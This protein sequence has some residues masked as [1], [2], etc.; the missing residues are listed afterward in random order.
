MLPFIKFLD[1]FKDLAKP[2]NFTNM[3]SYTE[4]LLTPYSIDAHRGVL[5]EPPGNKK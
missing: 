4:I 1:F 2:Q 5:H 3:R